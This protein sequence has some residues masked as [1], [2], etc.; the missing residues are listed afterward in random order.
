MLVWLSYPGISFCHSVVVLRSALACADLI[1]I[2]SGMSAVSKSFWLVE[3]SMQ[4]LHKHESRRNKGLRFF[5]GKG[6]VLNRQPNT[7]WAGFLTADCSNLAAAP[8][9]TFDVG[10]TIGNAWWSWKW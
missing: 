9:M 8:S 1:L 2:S 3:E 6:D 4:R 10:T 5:S 7:D